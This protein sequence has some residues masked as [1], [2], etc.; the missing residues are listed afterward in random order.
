MS[1]ATLSTQVRQPFGAV[2]GSRL[3]NLTNVKNKQNGKPHH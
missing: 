2:S 3:R 1:A